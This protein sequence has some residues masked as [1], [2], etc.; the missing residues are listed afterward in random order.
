MSLIPENV[1]E[2][3]SHLGSKNQTDFLV[4]MIKASLILQ[5]FQIRPYAIPWSQNSEK[6]TCSN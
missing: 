4:L 6:L 1:T 5:R 3:N 2:S